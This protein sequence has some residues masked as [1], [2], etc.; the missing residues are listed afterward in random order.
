MIL[1][2][3]FVVPLDFTVTTHLSASPVA[4]YP[5]SNVAEMMHIGKEW[6]TPGTSAFFGADFGSTK[7]FDFFAA[8]NTNAQVG[9]NQQFRVT[10]APAPGGGVAYTTGTVPFRGL[11]EPSAFGKYHTLRSIPQI[12]ANFFDYTVTGHSGEFQM[13]H[14][15]IGKKVEFE[16]FYN[17]ERAKGFRGFTAP[18]IS[19]G[20]VPSIERS[21]IQRALQFTFGTM[22]A[23]DFNRKYEPLIVALRHHR[24]IYL[25]FQPEDHVFRDSNTYFGWLKVPDFAPIGATHPDLHS[26]DME[27][28]SQI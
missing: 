18:D 8:L 24:P 15:I 16:K 20:G 28:T 17:Q 13:S 14:F 11:S 4:G 23:E 22:L 26:V 27:I 1:K 5:H 21:E 19:R 3:I 2:P 25:C 7:T 6:R 9:T 12:S 10:T